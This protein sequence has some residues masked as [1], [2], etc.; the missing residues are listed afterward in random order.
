MPLTLGMLSAGQGKKAPIIIGT[1]TRGDSVLTMS[2]TVVAGT[3]CLIV[4]VVG[5]D[6]S[7][8][9]WTSTTARWSNQTM[10]K[11]IEDASTGSTSAAASIFYMMN[12]TPGTG[13]VAL[14]FNNAATSWSVF[15]ENWENVS[16]IGGSARTDAGSTLVSSFSHTIPRSDA[17]NVLIS[18]ASM[19]Y[20]S[21]WTP[22]PGNIKEHESGGGGTIQGMIYKSRAEGTDTAAASCSGGDN[23][24]AAVTL[25][26]VAS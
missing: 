10:T 22:G 11:G 1:A 16:G 12:P 2:H 19:R 9:F 15:A 3:A 7:F 8:A 26:L 24:F 18:V 20:G 21:G 17:S 5:L 14:T 23:R 25:E 13:N 6:N 4:R